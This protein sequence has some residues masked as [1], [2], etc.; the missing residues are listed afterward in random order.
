MRTCDAVTASSICNLCRTFCM[1]SCNRI[2]TTAICSLR[3]PRGPLSD[4]QR[5]PSPPLPICPPCEPSPKGWSLCPTLGGKKRMLKTQNWLP[6]LLKMFVRNTCSIFFHPN[7]VLY[8]G[9]SKVPGGSCN[10]V[11]DV[12]LHE[13]LRNRTFT[14]HI[15]LAVHITKCVSVCL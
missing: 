4:P 13:V 7:W 6:A 12:S 11:W 10:S 15:P 1:S 2:S 5:S 14:Y 9:S 3:L 8:S